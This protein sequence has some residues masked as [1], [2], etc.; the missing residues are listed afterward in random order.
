MNQETNNS[1]TSI[2]WSP[3]EQLQ[4]PDSADDTPTNRCK[5]N[6]TNYKE[7]LLRLDSRSTYQKLK[8]RK[9]QP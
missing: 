7:L 3:A 4:D 5:T 9:M 2:Q 1:R 8:A 6:H